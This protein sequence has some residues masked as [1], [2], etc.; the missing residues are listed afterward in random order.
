MPKFYSNSCLQILLEKKLDTITVQ[1]SLIKR[2]IPEA[3]V[4]LHQAITKKKENIAL[5]LLLKIGELYEVSGI[6]SIRHG[7]VFLMIFDL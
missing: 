7:P 6:I 1:D 4:A 2:S 3:V 5:N